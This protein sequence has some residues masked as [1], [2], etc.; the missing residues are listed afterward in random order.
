MKQEIF[1]MERVTYQEHGVVLLQD[2][3]LQ[4]CQGE[5]MGMIPINNHG[6]GAFLKLLRANLPLYDGYIYYCSEKVNSWKGPLRST[7]RIS[8]I[9]AKSS[10]VEGMTV[11]D[12]IFVL[13]KGFHQELIRSRLLKAQMQPFL[14]DIGMDIS[15]DRYVE[16]LTIFERVV[17]ELL[18]GVILGN[19]LIVLC[20]IGALISYEELDQF[21]R[22]I[23][24]YADKGFSFLYVC[25]HF[26]ELSRICDR[27]ARMSNGRIQK[28]VSR[29]EMDEEIVRI[30]PDEYKSMVQYHRE[31]NLR[32]VKGEPVLTWIQEPEEDFGGFSFQVLR[33]EC[34]VLQVVENQQFQKIVQMLT[35]KKQADH[36]R[37]LIGQ[38][39]I[40]PPADSRIAVVQELAARTMIFPG[41]SY[42]ENLCM[43]L[44]QRMPFI[45]AN[46]KIRSNIRKEY[47]GILG[48]AVFDTA[49]ED[50]SEKQ[51]Y[52][53]IY[54]RILLQKPKVVF[55]IHPFQGADV[56]HRMFI[57]QMLEMLLGEGIAVVIVSVSL[58]DSL[59]M[60]DRLLVVE[61]NGDTREIERE[62]FDTIS[63]KVPWT[64]LYNNQVKIKET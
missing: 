52:Q 37:I 60:A 2:F 51:K 7:N 34:L 3:Q 6:L 40:L 12:N 22:I 15:G 57:W 5:I 56:A 36:V 31:N 13:R 23:R 32:I 20:E 62:K 50:L 4:I 24:Y 19:H 58:S 26:E 53:L 59:A 41:L 45:W 1:R 11:A 47:G 43:A 16:E 8:V 48:D 25:P 14:A 18:R 9:S 63:A 10:L 30:C 33:G 54:T 61:E 44:A 27:V 28:I 21:H 42:M 38:E 46:R 55:C 39:T 29:E 49:V 17:V 35:G 64:H